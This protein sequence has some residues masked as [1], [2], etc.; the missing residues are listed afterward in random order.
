[1]L[2]FFD[3]TWLP[4]LFYQKQLLG[5]KINGVW[6]REAYKIWDPLFI[7]STIELPKTTFRTKIGVGLGLG[8]IKKI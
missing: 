5:P 2:N 3:T 6:V 7:S 1:M 8:S 4:A